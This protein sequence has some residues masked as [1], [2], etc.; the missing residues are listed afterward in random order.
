MKVTIESAQNGFIARSDNADPVVVNDFGQM[1]QLL[2]Q[3]FNVKVVDKDGQEQDVSSV[4]GVTEPVAAKEEE[5][6]NSTKKAEA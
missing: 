4:T 3:A 2:I 6:K 1:L 5:S